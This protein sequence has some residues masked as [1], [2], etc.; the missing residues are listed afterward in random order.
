M[1][2]SVMFPLTCKENG[3]RLHINKKSVFWGKGISHIVSNS[4]LHNKYQGDVRGCHKMTP[5]RK[6]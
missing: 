1:L 6:H 5:V 2:L 4:R 3:A